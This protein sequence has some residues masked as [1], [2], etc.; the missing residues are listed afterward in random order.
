M[1]PA[2]MK[3]IA[4]AFR[5]ER[6]RPGDARAIAGLAT[7]L[8]YPSSAH[9]TRRRLARILRDLN[10]AA[11]VAKNSKGEVVG[12]VHMFLYRLLENDAMAEVGGLVIDERFR[13]QGAGELLMQR[14]ERWARAKGL[15]AVYLRSNI[16]RKR[17][18][19]FYLKLG[20]E[21]IKTQFA[22]KK[23]L[24]TKEGGGKKGVGARP[25]G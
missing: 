25:K 22:F 18:H 6:A 13:G 15:K 12:W 16:I 9:Q 19:A 21:I 5:V 8:G 1:G 7:Q 2:A 24:A 23:H 4:K 11:F 17:T 20:Y 14:V 10:H 3:R